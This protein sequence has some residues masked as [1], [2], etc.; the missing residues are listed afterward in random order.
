MEVIYIR[1]LNPQILDIFYNR[2]YHRALECCYQRHNKLQVRKD[3]LPKLGTRLE[4][5][6]LVNRQTAYHDFHHNSGGVVILLLNSF[7]IFVGY[8]LEL[9]RSSRKIDGLPWP[10]G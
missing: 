4:Q 8:L 1:D 2:E 5:L 7:F 9:H 6:F 10:D 3:S